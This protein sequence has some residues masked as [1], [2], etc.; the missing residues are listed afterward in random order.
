MYGHTINVLYKYA[1]WLGLVNQR[2]VQRWWMESEFK[3]R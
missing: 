1:N 3:N 2:E